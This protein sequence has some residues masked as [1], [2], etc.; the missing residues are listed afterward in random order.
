M[1]AILNDLEPVV[2]EP[3]VL[4][5]E[6]LEDVLVGK[7]SQRLPAHTSDDHTQQHITRIAVRILRA[8]FEADVLLPREDLQDE[9]FVVIAVGG[10]SGESDQWP[11]VADAAGVV[12]QMPDRDRVG[13]LG[14]LRY[15]FAD[16]IVERQFSL[17]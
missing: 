3:R 16:V 9:L 13:V 2:V 12:Q 8:R 1:R 15:V 4:H 17:L 5:A 10:K 14:Y 11:I 6:R 7:H